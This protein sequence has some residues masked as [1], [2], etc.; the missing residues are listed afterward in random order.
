MSQMT[1][2]SPPPGI[3]TVGV[4]PFLCAG[5][6]GIP[7]VPRQGGDLLVERPEAGK[8]NGDHP[9]EP[10]T[11]RPAPA[12]RHGSP[13]GEHR[14]QCGGRGGS[15]RPFSDN[16]S[17]VCFLK[18]GRPEFL[19]DSVGFTQEGGALIPLT[20]GRGC[21]RGMAGS[22]RRKEARS[23]AAR[24]GGIPGS[25]PARATVQP[26]LRAGNIGGVGWQAKIA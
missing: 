12:G 6:E 24:A 5:A 14:G 23:P 4:P 7:P 18:S 21:A 10:G 20:P 17:F 19:P 13:G 2:C 25:L 22:S 1:P 11:G 9:W 16:L 26:Q 3:H 15:R 8:P